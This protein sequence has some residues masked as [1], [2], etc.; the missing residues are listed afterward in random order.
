ME[1]EIKKIPDPDY[2][3]YYDLANFLKANK[4]YKEAI[5]YYSMS[6]KKIELDHYLI[7]NILENRGG[8]YERL[9]MWKEGEQDLKESLRL[10]PDQ[11]YVLN[12]LAYSWLE[13]KINID[14]ALVMLKKADEIKKNDAYIIDSLGWG[15]YLNANY[16]KAEKLLRRA[17]EL[18]PFD[19]IVSDHYGDIL[20][21]LNKNLQARYFWKQALNLEKKD[22]EF[23]DTVGQ[24]LIFGLLDES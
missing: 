12:Y 7:P 5:K 14:E 4:E 9:G 15:F 8:C 2:Y 24:K 11:P 17:N 18:M 23:M 22:K 21:K 6:L 10:S 13:K 20:W 1:R 16:L 19:P 3:N